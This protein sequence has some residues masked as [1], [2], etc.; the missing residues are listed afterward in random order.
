MNIVLSQAAYL[1]LSDR[2]PHHGN[3]E[4]NEDC[5]NE[6]ADPFG[7]GFMGVYVDIWHG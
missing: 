6:V 1:V 3:G 7:T 5:K 4:Y 2:G